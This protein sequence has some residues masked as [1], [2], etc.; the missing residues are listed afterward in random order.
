MTDDVST[1]LAGLSAESYSERLAA[2]RALREIGAEIGPDAERRIREVL[3]VETVPWVRGVLGDILE[4]AGGDP[5][6]DG[7]AIPAPVWD[8]RLSGFE[9]EL[10]REAITL[11]TSRVLHEI[12][13]I[14][15]RAKLAAVD[16]LGEG[17][18][19]SW[20]ERELNFL[21]D[22]CQ[23]LRRLNSATKVAAPEEFDLKE[24]LTRLASTIESEVLCPVHA[25]GPGPF[26]VIADRALLLLAL[27]NVIINAVEATLSVGPASPMRPVVVTWGADAGGVHVSVIDRGPGPP[28]FL[29]AMKTAG[30]STKEG[31]PGYG[32]ATASEALKSMRGTVE[33]RRNDRGG[34]TV[35][36]AWRDE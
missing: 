1:L 19:G 14:I 4:S 9:P 7:V 30:V 33:L 22:T 23:A 16:D 36:L 25:N 2:A 20:T 18:S 13:A 34:A 12:A 24:E 35:V 17:Y 29:A 8:D 6:D 26:T 28:A 15:G 21:A 27:R 3:A 5:L 11:A 32:L 31:H 10:V